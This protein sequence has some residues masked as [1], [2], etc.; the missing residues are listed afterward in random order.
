MSMFSDY[1][2]GALSDDEFRSLAAR[3]NRKERDYIDDFERYAEEED[4]II[5]TEYI[6]DCPTEF[7]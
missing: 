2:R 7:D 5:D 1:K 4:L 6:G 3:E